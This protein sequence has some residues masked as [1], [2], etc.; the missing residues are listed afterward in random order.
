MNV[1]GTIVYELL[2]LV[3]VLVP[4]ISNSVTLNVFSMTDVS[5]EVIPLHIAG[6][7][8]VF[9]VFTKFHMNVQRSVY[10]PTAKTVKGTSMCGGPPRSQFCGSLGVELL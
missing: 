7:V 2:A 4:P 5:V 3:V 10:V 8:L 6:I 1:C 9:I